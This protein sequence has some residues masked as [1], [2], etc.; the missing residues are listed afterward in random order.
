MVIIDFDGCF[1]VQHSEGEH[2]QYKQGCGLYFCGWC[3]EKFES[4]YGCHN[5]VKVCQHNLQPGSYYGT[6]DNFNRVHA[7]RRRA[8]VLTYLQ[9]VVD[10]QEREEIKKA[11]IRDLNDLGINI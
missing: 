3:L 8:S 9:N 5:H 1:A 6:K 10:V 4:N 7:Q 2:G 11:L